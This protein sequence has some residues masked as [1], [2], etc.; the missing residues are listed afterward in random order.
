MEAKADSL[1]RLAP[2]PMVCLCALFLGLL[3]LCPAVPLEYSYRRWASPLVPAAWVQATA[4]LLAHARSTAESV[5]WAREI[6]ALAVCSGEKAAHA[7]LPAAGI[8]L[9]HAY[10]LLESMDAM[11]RPEATEAGIEESAGAAAYGHTRKARISGATVRMSAA[12]AGVG[13]RKA[14]VCDDRHIRSHV[15]ASEAQGCTSGCGIAAVAVIAHG[16][17]WDPAPAGGR[18]RRA[19]SGS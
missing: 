6:C 11:R 1:G 8:L 12:M 17:V 7:L 5:A 19:A 14:V 3:A 16:R 15:S 9:L 2:S 13:D 18:R 4:G 10:L